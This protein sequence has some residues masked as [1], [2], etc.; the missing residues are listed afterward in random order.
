MVVNDKWTRVAQIDEGIKWLDEKVKA[1]GAGYVLNQAEFESE[2]GVGLVITQ[3]MIE[4]AV[5][6]LFADHADTI[7]AEGHDFNFAIFQNRMKDVYKWA[8]GGLV[9]QVIEK[10]KLEVCGEAPA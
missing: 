6:K 8:D 1:N 3:E 4:E 2:T 5:N 7:K 10:K 9:R